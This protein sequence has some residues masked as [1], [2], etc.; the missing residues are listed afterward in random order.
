[1]LWHLHMLG[2]SRCLVLIQNLPCALWRRHTLWHKE[3]PPH[4]RRGFAL[5]KDVA[6]ASEAW[7]RAKGN[8]TPPFTPK[9]YKWEKVFL[10][11]LNFYGCPIYFPCLPNR[12]FDLFNFQNRLILHPEGIEK[13]FSGTIHPYRGAPH[14]GLGQS[15]AMVV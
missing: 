6:A 10:T 1:M 4:L 11:P 14:T 8:Q 13:T 12:L 7:Q 3:L 15:I 9:S 5:G 2:V